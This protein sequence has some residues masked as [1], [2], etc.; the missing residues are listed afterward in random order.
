MNFT[1]QSTIQVG[2]YNGT[3]LNLAPFDAVAFDI[4]TSPNGANI[5]KLFI[6]DRY[7]GYYVIDLNWDFSVAAKNS[8]PLKTIFSQ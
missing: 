2:Q 7:F 4:A 6:L 3:G 1:G 5:S 8:V